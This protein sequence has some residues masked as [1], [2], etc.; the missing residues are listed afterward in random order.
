[1]AIFLNKLRVL[2]SVLRI[3][4]KFTQAR[5]L[6]YAYFHSSLLIKNSDFLSRKLISSYGLKK[7]FPRQS[8]S[9]SAKLYIQFTCKKCN[10]RNSKF[11]TKLAYE[12][13][14]VIIECEGCEN[15]HLIAD[16]LNWFSD[17]NGKRNIE[18]ILA[19]KGET[20][21]RYIQGGIC[22][23]THEET[24]LLLDEKK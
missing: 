4:P 15:N 6:R 3:A 24:V 14:V 12:K 17:L 5:S 2:N 10:T 20:V 21:R 18:E 19:E 8:S 11:I 9:D 13:G 1:M 23:V 7:D 22:E 16:N